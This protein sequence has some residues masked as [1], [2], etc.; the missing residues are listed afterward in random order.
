MSNPLVLH[1]EQMGAQL[2]AGRIPL[3]YTSPV[4]EYW[5]IRKHAGL[6]DLSHLGLV[7]VT[8]KDRSPFLNGLLTNEVLKLNE[9][10]GIRS[11][12]LNTKARVLADLYLYSRSDDLLIDTGDVP[13]ARV[14]ETL[15]R[16]IITE[17]V[18]VKDVTTELVHLTLQGQQ[19]ADNIRELF[20]TTFADMKSLQHRMLGPTMVV[21]R[22]RTGQ[23]GYD[24]MIPNVE[25]EAV[26]QGLLLKGVTPVGLNA[27][28]ILRLEAGYPRYGVDVDENIIILEAGYKD[29]ISFNKGCYLGQEVVARAT[30]IGRVN[31]NLV[32]FRT[33]SDH[34]PDPKTKFLAS[35]KDVGY[36]TSAAF[37]PGLKTV[38]GLGY[39]LRDFAKE[40]T[41]LVIESD[42]GPLPTVI[43][44]LA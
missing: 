3:S 22:D 15:D 16:F 12:L 8:G 14:K 37:S 26:W 13:G 20:G 39:A 1:H 25:A 34:A 4:E 44:K 10:S 7:Q 32:Q 2:E 42:K 5:A 28:E 6:A 38:V 18:Q 27:L 43:T 11:A 23:S 40:G 35:G 33:E 36:V 29:A 9:G 21:S 19:A 24:M 17:D 41:R 31:K 30:H